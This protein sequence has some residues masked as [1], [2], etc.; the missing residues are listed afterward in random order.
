MLSRG[1][2]LSRG[3][4]PQSSRGGFLLYHQEVGFPRNQVKCASPCHQEVGF[5]CNQVKCASPCHQEHHQ[6]HQLGRLVSESAFE[7]EDPGSNPVADMVDAARNTAWDL[8]KQPNN[9]RSNYPT[10]EWARR[11]KEQMVLLSAD[12]PHRNVL[13]FK[14]PLVFGAEEVEE[15]ISKLDAVLS[16]L[17]HTQELADDVSKLPASDCTA[18]ISNGAEVLMS[19]SEITT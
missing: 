10:Q 8:G 17:E 18:D 15:L 7:R 3:G 4:C 5:P 19:P 9:Y 16:E 11:L 6:H 13:K 12:G 14:S 1:G 2:S